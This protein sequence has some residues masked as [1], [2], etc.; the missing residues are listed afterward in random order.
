MKHSLHTRVLALIMAIAIVLSTGVLNSAGWLLASGGQETEGEETS[1]TVSTQPSQGGSATEIL[2]VPSDPTEAPSGAS[3]PTEA[4]S[5]ETTPTG[6]SAD[7]ADP[8][9]SV[10]LTVTLWAAYSDGKESH[11]IGSA[12]EVVFAEGEQTKT[13]TASIPEVEGY[14]FTTSMTMRDDGMYETT[15]SRPEA[16]GIQTINV[17]YTAV[18]PEPEQPAEGEVT[19]T[20][21]VTRSFTD[22]KEKPVTTDYPVTFGKEETSKDL[23]FTV[24]VVDGYGIT[25]SDTTVVAG[26]APGSF[27]KT[28][29]RPEQSGEYTISVVYAP[30]APL[31]IVKP[32]DDTP[33]ATYTFT[34]D[35]TVVDT[36]WV[37]NG[38]S[39]YAPASP[40]K[41][42]Y[43][44]T[45]WFDAEGNAFSAGTVEVTGSVTYTYTASFTPVYYV[46]FLNTEGVVCAT[47][48]GVS[49]DSISADVT[50]PVDAD[51][52]ITGWYTDS[53]LTNKVTSVTINGANITLYPKVEKGYWITYNSEGGTYIAPAFVAPGAV[54]QQPTAPTRE[55][56][57][58]QG[59][60]NGDTAFTFGSTLTESV[61]LTAHWQGNPNTRYT[62][63]HWQ[64]NAD[65][66][67]FSFQESETKTGTTG[68]ATAA[69][70]KSYEGFT[71]Q[72]IT[73]QTIA[74]DGST[75][76]NVYYDRNEYTIYF[77]PADGS[78]GSQTLICGKEEHT[79]NWRCNIFGC[80]KEEHTHDSS[81]YETSSS[82]ALF[83]ITAK[84]GANISDQ[85]PTYNGSSMW[86]T[87]VSGGP[88]QTNID[89]MPL[90][91]ANFYA[92]APSGQTNV[93]PYY[94]EAIHQ[95]GS[96]GTRASD[97]LYYVLHHNDSSKGT[98]GYS[99][100]DE[101][102]YPIT[103]F[104]VNTTLSSKNGD[105]YGS[106]KFY[107][108]RNSYEVKF[109]NNGPV[110]NTVSK[111]YQEDISDVSYTP[112][113]PAGIPAE[114]EFMG[115]YD[116]ELGQGE[117]YVFSG[118][119]PAKNITVY[120][121]WAAP[122]FVG[123][124]YLTMA[125][126]ASEHIAIPYGSKINEEDL[127]AVTVPEGYTWRGWATRDAEGNYIPFNFNTLIYSDITLYP[128]YTSN[129]SFTI[130][131]DANGGSGT[132]PV[133]P[134]TYADGSYADVMTAGSL[135]APTDKVFLGWGTTTSGG[136]IYQPGDK[137]PV[138]DA[139]ITL[140][141]IWG[142]QAGS[143]PLT[144]DP[145]GGTGTAS[146]I[147]YKNNESVVLKSN[148]ELGFTRD[149]YQFLGW[150]E[151]SS[152]TA[153][154]YTSGSTIVVDN[155]GTNTLYAVWKKMD[156]QVTYAYTG[157]VPA[158]AP[159]APTAQ[160]KTYNTTVAVADEPTLDGYYFSGWITSDATVTDGSFTMPAS[161]VAFTGSWT[162]R[163][164]L[165]YTVRYMW[166]DTLLDSK[167]VS[168][169]TFNTQSEVESPKTI[170]GYTPTST[171]TQQITITADSDANVIT[172]YY[173]KNV[174]LIANSATK[175][176]NENLQSVDGFTPNDITFEGVTAHGEGT[177]VGKYDVTF[178]DNYVGTI[179]TSKKYIVT[180]QTPGVLEITPITDAVTVTI[181]GNSAS[182]VYN[183][184]EQSVT[185]FTTDV[186]SKTIQVELAEGSKAE[187]KGTDVG[188]YQMGLTKDD[189][190]V[191]SDN[192]SSINVVVVDGALEITPTNEQITV[193]IQEN[194]M[195]V[196][197]NGQPQTLSG[198]TV[199]SISSGPYTEGDFTFV[200]GGVD[201]VTKT[202]VGTYPMG[203]LPE[204]FRN[205][206][207][208][209]S[210]VTF[211]IVDGTLTINKRPVTLTSATASKEYDGTPLTAETVT[212]SETTK[213]SGFVD[214]EGVEGYTNFA[215]AVLPNETVDNTF[216]Y[217][218]KTNTKAGNYDITVVNGTL[219]IN[220]R[221]V[222]YAITVTA[223]SG[224]HEYDA[225]PF[226]VSGFESIEGAGITGNAAAM[227]FTLNGKTFTISGL[228]ASRTETHV[229]PVKQAGGVDVLPYSGYEVPVTGTAVILDGNGNDVTAQFSVE[230]VSGV[231]MIT[232]RNV[233]LTS[234]TD[235]KKYDKSP[236]TNGNVTVT[237]GSFAN[238]DGFTANVTGK[239]L[240]IG[241]SDNK[242]T[243]K[244]T[245]GA[246]PQDYRVEYVYG[247]LTVTPPDDYEI[248]D[249]SHEAPDGVYGLGDTI[250][251][252]I[253]VENIF[254]AEATVTITEQEGV[255]FLDASGNKI[256]QTYPETTIAAGET[257]TVNAVYTVQEKD[258]LNGSFTNTVS[259]DISATVDEIPYEGDDDDDDTVEDLEEPDPE[260]TVVKTTTSTPKDP[261]LG[262]ATGETI[263]YEITVEN[264]GNL[265]IHNIQ[266]LDKISCADEA[267]ELTLNNFDG[268]LA[269]GEKVTFSF[270]HR[271][272]EEDLGKTIINEATAT[273]TNDTEEDEDKEND[274][275]TDVDDEDGKTEDR[276]E[277]IRHDLTISK[278]ITNPKE[279][280]KLQTPIL[281]EIVITNTGNVTERNVTV[282]DVMINAAHTKTRFTFTDIAGGTL[283][284]G[285]VVFASLAPGESRVI[286]CQY[287]IGSGDESNVVGN[288]A[289]VTSNDV[290]TVT[291][292]TVEA[293]VETQYEL[294]ILYLDE[295]WQVI[296]GTY[297]TKKSVGY[298]YSITSP[299]VEGYTP[300]RKVV[301]SGE[302]GMPAKNVWEYVIYTKDPVEEEPTEPTVTEP[303]GT[304]PTEPTGT[305]PTEPTY[306]LT[307]LPDEKT[308]QADA[309][310]EGDHTCCL[311]HF[312]IMLVS[313]ILLG[314]YTSDRKKLQKSIF[315]L[316][317]TLK[318]EGVT[319]GSD[320]EK[321]A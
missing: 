251:F 56:Y 261:D 184:S 256:G 187:A 165:S 76:V 51:Q 198:Y 194:S 189:F 14:T 55:G 75:I 33:V 279:I 269:P 85:W 70:A 311:M 271:V 37:K 314:F 112:T 61:T 99:V 4:P 120:A 49:G 148:T 211:V 280:Y 252:T 246:D 132:V 74:G 186:G 29:D 183:T 193:T 160:T 130:T 93:V 319:V 81:C 95:D 133:D 113:R 67:N 115:W 97:G 167:T 294:T 244:L 220:P 288:K 273:G 125:G 313:M 197:Y 46:F 90:G 2:T 299:V 321:N 131:Y 101:D 39:V 227:T 151:N 44:F 296:A 169:R 317:R 126:G 100:T 60:F 111:K 207:R 303:T 293:Q 42:G 292:E 32:V 20:V 173:Y 128:Y 35:G 118:T 77:W 141:A 286:S 240:L 301:M 291:S 210:N 234:A 180:A 72:T 135:T 230:T 92:Y 262:Y 178:A 242:F 119:M 30:P 222:P 312:L 236:L 59:W 265:T 145:N 263:T 96:E 147:V 109:I 63:I 285:K 176:Y 138:H 65:D 177:D 104:T 78:S 268:T 110:E 304:D 172:F 28:F 106:A 235:S 162:I 154:Q 276:T 241:S 229:N 199:K 58:F 88:Y 105:S 281:Y 195:T 94:V 275:P 272:V 185:G 302:D 300:N 216:S 205:T 161:D 157:E 266:V 233:T 127:P 89:T 134:K 66:D 226:T 174:T 249:K 142:D 38:E 219:T 40:E 68:E 181:T 182:K 54:T 257:L 82:G 250:T 107:Y 108:Y 218:L 245:G 91:G 255:E 316:K 64:E 253:T 307:P 206:N 287:K 143:A 62:V 277:P 213:T 318:N 188:T 8:Q 267:A 12:R 247:K 191:T 289:T 295:D 155:Q 221:T 45:G 231:L 18:E 270:E 15:L 117:A 196:T 163:D 16:D 121:K 21:H 204:H 71:A 283:Q 73:Q 223:N 158:G 153:A 102:R 146:T 25:V 140:Y 137:I 238:G 144:Y 156:F 43:K 201:V 53:G 179:D 122:E 232:P 264:T 208:N 308:P 87:T 192:Y 17:N 116:N 11:A 48:E 27:T 309:D 260:L 34:V 258:L 6:E 139:N 79:H 123:T 86:S 315:D 190:V 31:K 290:S 254:D 9:D 3:D 306:D 22:D 224:E 212:V 168:N 136:T 225:Q 170:S 36:Q 274:I 103:G 298:R 19:I 228:A 278:T 297:W 305:D 171:A 282:E 69:T 24:P 215:S 23:T 202:D 150:S 284:D 200:G 80:D 159:A 214:G 149:G 114:Y 26:E 259:V 152:A 243:Y 248:V 237:S 203:L 41:E 164:D 129:Q 13:F 52:A 47:K 124:V 57:T 5:G 310:M 320:H 10:K 166:G 217:T 239:Q 83:T 84:Y 1:G 50:F 175:T 209:F 7:P 98:S